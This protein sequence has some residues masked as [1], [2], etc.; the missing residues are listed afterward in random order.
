MRS[1]VICL[2]PLKLAQGEGLVSSAVVHRVFQHHHRFVAACP[3][4]HLPARGDG[5]LSIA[6]TS[7]NLG[8]DRSPRSPKYRTAAGQI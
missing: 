2:R 4:L 8:P 7:E 6:R 3:R 1:A 5:A